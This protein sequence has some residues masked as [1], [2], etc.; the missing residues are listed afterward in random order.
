M[1]VF[2]QI[3]V[4]SGSSIGPNFSIIPNVGSVDIPI[5][6]ITQLIEGITIELSDPSTTLITLV[7]LGVCGTTYTINLGIT[8]TTT[9]S[10]TTTTTLDLV[11]CKCYKLTN[12]Q[13]GVPFTYTYNKCN[14]GNTLG[15]I[16]G[17]GE[18]GSTV[19][20][21]SI[22]IPTFSVPFGETSVIIE[23]VDN[24]ESEFIN[25]PSPC[26][27]APPPPPPPPPLLISCISSIKL[28]FSSFKATLPGSSLDNPFGPTQLKT[29][30]SFQGQ[31]INR[32]VIPNWQNL[33]NIEC[34][35]LFLGGIEMQELFVN[36]L[37]PQNN[38]YS[39][40]L[41]DCCW[42]HASPPSDTNDY[43]FSGGINYT[44]NLPS[45]C[46]ECF[47][48]APGY[49]SVTCTQP[50]CIN[51]YGVRV[52]SNCI[53]G[54]LNPDNTVGR[55]FLPTLLD[56]QNELSP[57]QWQ[58]LINLHIIESGS[59]GWLVNS[60]LTNIYSELSGLSANLKYEYL[61]AILEIGLVIT[62]TGFGECNVN[63]TSV[64]SYLITNNLN[65][66]TTST[67]ST[68]TTTSSSTTTTTT[69]QCN[70]WDIVIS[71]TDLDNA[72]F[73]EDEEGN[74]IPG[75]INVSFKNCSG[76]F[77]E[78]DFEVAGTYPSE[79]CSCCT[80]SIWYFDGENYIE[81][82]LST[83]TQTVIDCSLTTTTTILPCLCVQITGIGDSCSPNSEGT[84][85]DCDG[86]TQSYF[87]PI[88]KKLYICTQVVPPSKFVPGGPLITEI[89]G[90]IAIDENT[91]IKLMEAGGL[92]LLYTLCTCA[93][94]TTTTT[95]TSSTTT[96]TTCNCFVT[97][98]IAVNTDC[99]DCEEKLPAA[100]KYTTCEGIQIMEQVPSGIITK[101]EDCAIIGTINAVTGTE[102]KGIQEEDP[103]C[104]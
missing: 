5:A 77:D 36:S 91:E 64:D 54:E 8:T 23:E 38:C 37:T 35:P 40:D 20:I 14:F 12:T 30:L 13:T 10:T 17:A 48:C 47:G 9:S 98:I 50:F 56:I 27:T 80:P 90:A 15:T 4:P 2:I 45:F 93:G 42:G 28:L 31:T 22:G 16:S 60:L 70:A 85:I 104:S 82:T 32:C 101:L 74:T 46:A 58:D 7:S 84:Y 87:L 81:S 97:S 63:F 53:T 102:I 55:G 41:Q 11:T 62:Q 86:N 21:C 79:I 73:D 61:K 26:Y 68:S 49:P 44:D 1:Q 25:C 95:S 71:Q 34:G 65:C 39:S 96:T 24:S 89:S 67:T 99:G 66:T 29:F 103:C 100:V 75:V 51:Q 43:C 88:N 83:A 19:Y 92:E 94:T 78:I 3:S 72:T 57:S 18:S 6:S 59:E 33:C 69:C 76:L 52:H